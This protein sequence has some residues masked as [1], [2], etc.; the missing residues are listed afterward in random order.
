[1]GFL[2][3]ADN[4][5]FSWPIETITITNFSIK[6]RILMGKQ[7]NAREKRAREKRKLKRKKKALQLLRKQ[8]QVQ[9]ETQPLEVKITQKN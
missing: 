4:H 6:W 9:K 2:S 7:Y 8:K 3:F 5:N 1:M